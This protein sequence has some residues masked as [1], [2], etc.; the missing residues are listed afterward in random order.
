MPPAASLPKELPSP[1]TYEKV[2]PA[3]FTIL[4]LALTSDTLPLT[5]VDRYADDF[6]AHA[7][8]ADFRGWLVDFHGE[9]KPAVRV[10]VDPDKLAQLGLTPRGRARSH[11]ARRP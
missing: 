10:R 1:P 6:I 11:S 5:E 8:V 7:D 3:D 2:N 9:Q 4:S